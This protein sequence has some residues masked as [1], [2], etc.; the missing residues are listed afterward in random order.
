MNPRPRPIR[1][2]GI[3][4]AFMHHAIFQHLSP[5]EFQT[6]NLAGNAP[7]ANES[8]HKESA[9]GMIGLPVTIWHDLMRMSDWE[10]FD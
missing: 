3:V 9:M 5:Q 7:T 1:L 8:L 4:A 2:N 10:F 6:M